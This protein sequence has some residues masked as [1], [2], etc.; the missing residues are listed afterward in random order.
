MTANEANSMKTLRFHQYGEPAA[1]LHL[2]DAPLPIPGPGHIRVRVQ[3][4]GLNPAD[5][6]LC[7]GLFPGRLPRGIGLD[8][9]GTVDV[10]G[11]G[12]QDVVPGDAVLG[13]ADFAGYDSAGASE[14]A[15]LHHWARRPAGLD[16]VEAAA[17]P[18]AFVTAQHGLDV[19]GV[20]AGQTLMVN[21]AG[22]TIGY[23]AVQIAL[24]R[25]AR[26]VATA[27]TT[28]A[29]PLRALGAL[30]T[31]YGAGMAGRV[32]ALTGTPPDLILDTAPPSGV[33][34]TL[35]EIAGNPAHVLT[36]SDLAGANELG[37]RINL[38]ADIPMRYDLLERFA[39]LAAE[40]TFS[41]PVAGTF[42]LEDWRAALDLSQ[43]GQARGK[44][45]LLLQ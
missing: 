5:W 43:S 41:V 31:S 1:V 30:V 4:C 35:I 33:L 18:L 36:V 39:Q 8:V 28:Y 24:M 3:A 27:G 2:E 6:A 32:L 13:A 25:G 15:V 10:V 29:E 37:V 21:G 12:V 20:T 16:P 22:T 45:V 40:R 7:Q 34:P 11:D 17:L 19:L 9:A 14:F 38:T 42:P 44:L 26:V 23:A